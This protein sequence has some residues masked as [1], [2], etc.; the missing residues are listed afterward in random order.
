VVTQH[1]RNF[2][3]TAYAYSA[4]DTSSTATATTL[5]KFA[6]IIRVDYPDVESLFDEEIG[7]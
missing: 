6:D 2:G 4:A 1:H 7:K 3:T 5:A